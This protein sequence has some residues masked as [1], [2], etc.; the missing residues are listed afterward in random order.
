MLTGKRSNQYNMEVEET[1]L[2]FMKID[3]FIPSL[4]DYA[5]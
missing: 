2:T 1:E 3:Q 5:N 4:V